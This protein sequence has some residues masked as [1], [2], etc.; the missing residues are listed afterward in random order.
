MG[1]DS[2]ASRTPES[3]KVT[4]MTNDYDVIVIGSGAGGL[5]AAVA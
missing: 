4:Q 2:R 5:A 3:K 1:G